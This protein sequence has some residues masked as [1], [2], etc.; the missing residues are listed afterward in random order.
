MKMELLR[1]LRSEEGEIEE[2]L[3]GA[4]IIGAGMIPVVLGIIS[5][6]NLTTEA[7]EQ[8]IRD[9]LWSGY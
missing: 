9:M 7:G 1:F 8:R 3:I 2:W 6:L 4:V 5:A